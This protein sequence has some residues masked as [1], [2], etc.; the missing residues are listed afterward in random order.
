MKNPPPTVASHA[1]DTPSEVVGEEA[2]TKSWKR[3]RS[4][5]KGKVS[6]MKR[7]VSR[8]HLVELLLTK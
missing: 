5:R 4:H 6:S 8:T 7:K 2:K 3:K 1:G